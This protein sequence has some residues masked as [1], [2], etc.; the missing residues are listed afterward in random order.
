M[1]THLNWHVKDDLHDVHIFDTKLKVCAFESPQTV[2][3]HTI[4]NSKLSA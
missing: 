1:M 4:C 2:S 3:S